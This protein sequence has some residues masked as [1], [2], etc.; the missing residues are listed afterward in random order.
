MRRAAAL[1]PNRQ[2][3]AACRPCGGGI[4]CGQVVPPNTVERQLTLPSGALLWA[5][6]GPAIS[7]AIINPQVIGRTANSHWH[8]KGRKTGLLLDAAQ[9][10]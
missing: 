6:S 10:C 4:C 3:L 8:E 5:W 2:G 9:L 7:V 1:V